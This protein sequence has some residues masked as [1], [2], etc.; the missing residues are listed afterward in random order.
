MKTIC[1]RFD[2]AI[3]YV[4]ILYVYSGVQLFQLYRTLAET[5]DIAREEKDASLF[6]KGSE[7]M[8]TWRHKWTC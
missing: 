6:Q 3:L 1:M 5:S 2:S 8:D 4:Y 7:M